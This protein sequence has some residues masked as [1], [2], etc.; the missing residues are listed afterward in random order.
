M[1]LILENLDPKFVEPKNKTRQE[2]KPDLTLE[3]AALVG[4]LGFGFYK[5]IQQNSPKNEKVQKP[6]P[7]VTETNN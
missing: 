1:I 6:E 7:L 2:R 5:L 4:L 3:T